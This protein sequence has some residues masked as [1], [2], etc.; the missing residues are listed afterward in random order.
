MCAEIPSTRITSVPYTSE[1][2]MSTETS[3]ATSIRPCML[4]FHKYWFFTRDSIYAIARICYRSPIRPS[5][6]PFVCHMGDSN[7]NG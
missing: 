4:K 6:R 3:E 1:P 5:V 7:K 2:V